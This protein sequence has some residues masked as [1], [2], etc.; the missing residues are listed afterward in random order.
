MTWQNK[1]EF[2]IKSLRF[3]LLSLGA[4]IGALFFYTIT[5]IFK[6]LFKIKLHRHG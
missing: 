4:K 1:I 3:L 5:L 2:Q 6:V